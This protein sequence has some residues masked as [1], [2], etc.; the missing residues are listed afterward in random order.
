MNQSIRLPQI[1]EKLVA[2]TLTSRRA[3]NQTR[4]VDQLHRNEPLTINT[5]RIPRPIHNTKLFA[6]ASC[7]KIRDSPIRLDR[8][9]R[10]IRNRNNRQSSSTEESALTSVRLAYYTDLHLTPQE[11]FSSSTAHR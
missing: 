6:D 7:A 2:K 1:I 3:R 10:I 9:K 5:P 11:T 4:T 8:S